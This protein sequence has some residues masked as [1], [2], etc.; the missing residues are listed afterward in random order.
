MVIL[1]HLI[2]SRGDALN[3]EDMLVRKVGKEETVLA[4]IGEYLRLRL[5]PLS[6]AEDLEEVVYRRRHLSQNISFMSLYFGN[7]L[8]TI[9]LN[10]TVNFTWKKSRMKSLV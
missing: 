2:W 10:V 4:A 5:L 9:H 3:A 8:R 1:G 7:E 6:L